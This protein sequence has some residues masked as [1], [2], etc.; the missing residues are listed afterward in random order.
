MANGRETY[1]WVIYLAGLLGIF[2]V[3]FV[4][5]N[6]AFLV[7]GQ[8]PTGIQRSWWTGVFLN[9]AAPLGGGVLFGVAFVS[10]VIR[11]KRFEPTLRAH[12]VRTV[13][14]YV[15]A[16]WVLGVMYVKRGDTDLGLWV[17]IIL[18]PLMGTVGAL[19]VDLAMT[20]RRRGLRYAQ[21]NGVLGG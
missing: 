20:V 10:R 7:A 6:A 9:F 11:A 14:W 3:S 1:L 16:I 21:R 15:F 8:L 18:W 17:Q 12:L 13:S 5:A 2:L 4:S 19:F